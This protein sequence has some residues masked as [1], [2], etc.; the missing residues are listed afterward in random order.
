MR[1]GALSKE[2][3]RA[4]VLNDLATFL[5]P[6]AKDELVQYEEGNWPANP[7]VG[8]AYSS[9]YTPGTWTQYGKWLRAPV[10]GPQ[11][12]PGRV[13]WAGTEVRGMPC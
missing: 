5:G 9:F 1:L 10:P 3:R 13:V 11:G 4:A 12:A 8:G 6:R 2:E 7:F